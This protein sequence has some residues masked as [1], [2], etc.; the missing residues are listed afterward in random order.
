MILKLLL[1]TRIL[2]RPEERFFRQKPRTDLGHAVSGGLD[3]FAT[4]SGRDGAR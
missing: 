3:H 2:I 4:V 1:F